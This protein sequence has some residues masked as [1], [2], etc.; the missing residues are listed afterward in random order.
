ML[1]DTILDIDKTL[2]SHIAEELIGYLATH[3]TVDLKEITSVLN[4]SDK[5]RIRT[6]LE[7][8][9]E[10][11]IV[12]G[13][14]V[15]KRKIQYVSIPEIPPNPE[16]SAI[17]TE[18]LPLL[19]ALI[20]FKEPRVPSIAA[21]LRVPKNI[22]KREICRLVS[23]GHISGTFEE[24]DKFNLE[25]A[26]NPDPL[27]AFD[28]SPLGRMLSGACIVHK[29]LTLQ[30]LVKLTGETDKWVLLKE[31]LTA[32]A[33][34]TLKGHLIAKGKNVLV[35]FESIGYEQFPLPPSRLMSKYFD[36]VA[37][38]ISSQQV[39]LR[40]IAKIIGLSEL[41]LRQTIYT[42]AADGTIE[43]VI[44]K[45][46]IWL[47]RMP[48][49]TRD[50]SL[51]ELTDQ[52]RLVLGM[53]LGHKKCSLRSLARWLNVDVRTVRQI[54]F[55]LITNDILQ[56]TLSLGPKEE[57]TRAESSSSE[58]E[59]IPLETTD[60]SILGALIVN[61]N[62]ALPTLA[63]QFGCST[64]EIERALYLLLAKRAV[65][66]EVQGRN[67][68]LDRVLI[69]QPAL[70]N[71]ELDSN[72]A[73]VTLGY[74]RARIEVRFR[75]MAKELGWDQ[76]KVV[77]NVY[78]LAGIGTI[79]GQ[80]DGNKFRLQDTI[81]PDPIRT[82]TELGAPYA[83]LLSFIRAQSDE[84][85]PLKELA[86]SL[87]ISEKMVRVRLCRLL[88]EGL[89]QGVLD[90]N[91]FTPTGDTTSSRSLQSEMICVNCGKPLTGLICSH[92]GKEASQCPVCS[93]LL[94][95]K[96]PNLLSCPHCKVIGHQA[97]FKEWI[98]IRGKCPTCKTRLTI[99]MLEQ[100]SSDNRDTML[101]LTEI[102]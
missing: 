96:D 74:L 2:E 45:G 36:T 29:N 69:E 6:L 32:F 33:R 30:D 43:P 39:P 10:R 47:N 70:S 49:I 5:K 76:K 65:E 25:R 73:I 28:Q 44:A 87:R 91:T 67:F 68:L 27:P 62:P 94:D 97:H 56:G 72:E 3:H 82:P 38:L 101:E 54:F 14:F 26:P 24:R 66:G 11:D 42:L 102:E 98:K 99:E 48:T 61:S 7:T 35:E 18:S 78:Y 84:T 1:K 77:H 46:D 64:T 51:D 50:I 12:Q 89:I 15:G 22:V 37:S 93:K 81:Q 23:K 75:D 88:G 59:P 86:S 31:I 80:V 63:K 90:S 4:I 41:E 79:R 52:E 34:Q 57:F 8:L 55:K 21:L 92:C 53:T 19:G 100:V 17:P 20:G 83:E 40:K 16:L 95:I 85:F 13:E 9:L 71:S 60:F 58:L